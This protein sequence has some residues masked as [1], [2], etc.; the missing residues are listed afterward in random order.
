MG[1]FSTLQCC[2]AELRWLKVFI[3]RSLFFWCVSI[4]LLVGLHTQTQKKT[5]TFQFDQTLHFGSLFF[6]G[7]AQQELATNQ[8]KL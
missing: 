2:F 6:S 5:D 8:I 1:I 7:T 4:S 3:R